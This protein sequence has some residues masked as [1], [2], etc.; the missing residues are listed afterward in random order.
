ML[1]R[2]KKWREY[3]IHH[4]GDSGRKNPPTNRITA[5]GA[6]QPSG[7]L[8][9]AFPVAKKQAYPTQF[10]HRTPNE[11]MAANRPTII[12]LY[13][14]RASSALYTGT[15]DSR[16]PIGRPAMT[17]P[18]MSIP[19]FMAAVC[20][21]VPTMTAPELDKQIADTTFCMLTDSGGSNNAFLSSES[22]CHPSGRKPPN[23]GS[24]RVC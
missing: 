11:A 1:D 6:W 17:R 22:I 19:M 18:A 7:I 21:M 14:G 5:N 23:C 24:S 20:I 15:I 2:V 10:E 8:H 13:L 9:C 12:P 4:R 3:S 16:T